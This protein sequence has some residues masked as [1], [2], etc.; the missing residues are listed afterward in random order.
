MF[1]LTKKDT[2]FIWSPECDAVFAVLKAKVTEAPGAD[3]PERETAIP[4]KIG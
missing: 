1:D 3:T 4:S 2:P